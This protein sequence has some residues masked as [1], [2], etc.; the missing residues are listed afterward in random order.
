MPMFHSKNV[1]TIVVFF[2][3]LGLCSM[4]NAFT[5][6]LF[7]AFRVC[8]WI[9]IQYKTFQLLCFVFCVCVFFWGGGLCSLKIVFSFLSPARLLPFPPARKCWHGPNRS[10]S[11][12]QPAST[13]PSGRGVRGQREGLAACSV[14]RKRCRRVRA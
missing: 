10:T 2:V 4:K 8:F 11:E 6:Y 13:P 7:F 5:W 9:F 1:S 12:S 3:C 14:T